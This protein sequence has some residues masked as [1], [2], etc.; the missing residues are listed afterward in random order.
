MALD[1]EKLRTT[2]VYEARAP[3]GSLLADLEQIGNLVRDAEAKRHKLRRYAGLAMILGLASAVAAGIINN[4]AFGF[5][6]F[7]AFAAGVGLFIYSF[8]T[9]RDMHKHHDRY[10]LLRD[11]SKT[12]QVD[13][14]PRAKFAVKLAIKAQPKL[15]REELVPQKKNGKQQFFEEDFL[16]IAG[17]LL[18]GTYLE[19]TVTENTR[20]RTHT[21]PRGKTKTKTRSRYLLSVRLGYPSDLYGDARPAQQALQEEFRLPASATLKNVGVSEKT[22]SIKTMVGEEKEIPNASAMVCLGAYRILN[23]ARRAAGGAKGD[24][25]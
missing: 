16:T 22:I 11:L 1:V 8:V 18:D 14:D 4:N 24:S 23:L 3:F 19:Q 20:K 15:L 2:G 5:C 21:N 9:G 6:A 10:E 25:K 17:E 7:L 12:V 13:A